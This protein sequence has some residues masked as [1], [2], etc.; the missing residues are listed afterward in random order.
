ME[1]KEERNEGEDVGQRTSEIEGKVK[2][3]E[4]ENGEPEGDRFAE[5]DADG[6]AVQREDVHDAKTQRSANERLRG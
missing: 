2:L 6:H 3:S 5:L 1:G 4:S